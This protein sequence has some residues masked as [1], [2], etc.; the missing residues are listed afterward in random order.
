M[1]KGQRQHEASKASFINLIDKASESKGFDGQVLFA[2]SLDADVLETAC[3]NKK[4]NLICF[5]DYILT[6][7]PDAP[8]A[9]Y[10]FL[11]SE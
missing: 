8:D 6:L 1:G 11:E 3:A 7:K 5:D 10:K 2:T 9:N 4:V